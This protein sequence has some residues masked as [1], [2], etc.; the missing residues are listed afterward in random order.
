[1]PR[2]GGEMAHRWGMVVDLDRCT[3]CEACVTAC[4]AE[5]NIP[6]VSPEQAASSSQA[7]P[8]RGP[9][10]ARS[11]S[12]CP[13]A[14]W[15]GPAS[16]AFVE[17]IPDERRGGFLAIRTSEAIAVARRLRERG[18]HSDARG[19]DA[20]NLKMSQERAQAIH[21][22]LVKKGVDRKRLSHAGYGFERPV[23]LGE[24]LGDQRLN[25]ACAQGIPQIPPDA[26]HNHG[27]LDLR[28]RNC[29]GRQDLIA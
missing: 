27:W 19:S 10:P 22:Y 8:V 17:P 12:P 11:T 9:A 26:S 28:F 20:F 2:D 3:G 7:R 5:N 25:V 29:G 24:T 4:H 21:G 6:S 18:V 15:D 23:L 16:A 1:M 14:S 13:D